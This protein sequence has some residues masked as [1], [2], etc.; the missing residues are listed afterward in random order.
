[1]SVVASSY[2]VFTAENQ[3]FSA[4]EVWY[5]EQKVGSSKVIFVCFIPRNGMER[6]KKHMVPIQRVTRIVDMAEQVA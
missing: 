4:D 5:E 6:G 3:V 2:R 1:M